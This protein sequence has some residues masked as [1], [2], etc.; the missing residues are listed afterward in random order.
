MFLTT[1]EFKECAL[2]FA[3]NALHNLGA[4]SPALA[5]QKR[6][7]KDRH[8]NAIFL[9]ALKERNR[10]IEPYFVTHRRASLDRMNQTISFNSAEK[11][12]VRFRVLRLDSQMH[13]NAMVEQ[14][15]RLR[16]IVKIKKL[17]V[18]YMFEAFKLLILRQVCIESFD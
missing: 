17:C 12:A 7:K 18:V 11:F 2:R 8:L 10:T 16:E 1:A 6:R 3:L 5:E 4:H 15:L 13:L 9:R 14:R